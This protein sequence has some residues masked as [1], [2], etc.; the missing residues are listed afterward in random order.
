MRRALV[1][2]LVMLASGG[3]VERI[4]EHRVHGALIDAGVPDPTADCMARRMVHRLSIGQ[5]RKLE[6][7]RGAKRSLHGYLKAVERVGDPEVIGV[8]ASSA[9]LCSTG[10]AG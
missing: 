4:T 2:A 6:A 8:T 7:L 3:C 5:L 10:L 1:L 9:A